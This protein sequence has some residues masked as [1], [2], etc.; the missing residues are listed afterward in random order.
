MRW[1]YSRTSIPVWW[2]GTIGILMTLVLYSGCAGSRNQWADSPLPGYDTVDSTEV[3]YTWT[4]PTSGSLVHHYLVQATTGQEWIAPRAKKRITVPA[5]SPH[6]VRVRGVDHQGTA[7]PW[8]MYSD[9]WPGRSE[10]DTLERRD[11][12]QR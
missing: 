12:W 1:L 7:G 9:S 3:T 5:A 4:P 11:E 8:S 2:I 6:R 10:R